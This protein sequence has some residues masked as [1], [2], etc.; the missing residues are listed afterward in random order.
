M[1]TCDFYLL[2][3]LPVLLSSA[4]TEEKL[5]VTLILIIEGTLVYSEDSVT[6]ECRIEDDLTDWIYR[7][8][9]GSERNVGNQIKGVNGHTYTIKSVTQG[10]NGVYRCEA[11]G[12][13]PTHSSEFSNPVELTVQERTVRLDVIS[14]H[15]DGRIFEGDQVSLQCHVSG[16]TVGWKYEL[17]MELDGIQS[18]Y[19]TKKEGIFTI[20][21][22]TLRHR[23]FYCQAG[24]GRP[25]MHSSDV[26]KLD[27]SELFSEPHLTVHPSPL[28]GYG[29][30]VTLKCQSMIE[31]P[32]KQLVYQFHKETA[33]ISPETS[34]NQ[35]TIQSF[36][37]EN[38]GS[39]WCDVAVKGTE[40]KRSNQV[41]VAVSVDYTT[42]NVISLGLS[43]L[44][45][46]VLLVLV[47]DCFWIRVLSVGVR[48]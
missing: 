42:E 21:P 39:Y 45:L 5:K 10:E 32:E 18:L 47:S 33:S 17:H 8:Y 44:V 46:L 26:I 29:H 13:S 40:K 41:Q 43:G 30:N 24:K 4:Q 11:Y 48:K 1:Q 23:T 36:Q 3:F 25:H 20:N 2:I 37:M 7:W 22:V 34:Q 9:K 28:V 27:V 12:S 16:N 6:L 14:S 15:T 19:K 38:T 31:F 35:F